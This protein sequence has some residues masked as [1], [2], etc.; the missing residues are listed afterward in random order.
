MSFCFHAKLSDAMKKL[1]FIVFMLVS[2]YC[3]LAQQTIQERLGYPKSTK[4]LIIHADDIGVSHSE[5]VASIQAMEKGVV[6]SGS[7]MVPCPWFPEIAVYAKDHPGI[8]LGLHLTLTAEWKNYKWG[9]VLNDEVKSLLTD[10]GFL[11]DGSVNLAQ[12]AKIEEVEKELRAQI[13]RSIQFGIDPTHFDSHMGILFQSPALL[14]TY[15]KLGR[16]YKVPV[17]LANRGGNIDIKQFINDK[18]V[19]TDQVYIATP[20]DY[21]KGSRNFYVN[22]FKSIQP[23]LNC[24]LLHAAFDDAE[25][26]AVTI[27]HPDYGAAWRQADFDFFT[28]EECRKLIKE[29]NIQLITWKEIRD[30]LVRGK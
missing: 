20:A 12:T 22:V 2:G 5:N 23:G 3:L 9:P 30:K 29:Q 13:E 26:Q 14:Q 19:I 7:I 8:D 28:S 17:L 27:D 6:N 18:D 1:M 4:L 25:M 10:K 11:T 16:E 24:I 21:A 15:I